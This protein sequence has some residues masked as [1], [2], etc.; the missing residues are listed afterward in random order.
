MRDLIEDSYDLVVSAL[1]KRV[2]EELGWAP[3]ATSPSSLSP[4]LGRLLAVGADEGQHAFGATRLEPLR[5]A[6][7]PGRSSIREV[8][9]TRF[10]VP[11][12]HH[13]G[14][15]RTSYAS[16]DLDGMDGMDALDGMDVVNGPR[17]AAV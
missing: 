6:G 4:F 12:E 8:A 3:G 5:M 10:G 15:A 7:G 16:S 9:L 17:P 11:P 14:P 1:P 13:R 2:R